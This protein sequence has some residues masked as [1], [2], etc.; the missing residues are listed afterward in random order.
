[1]KGELPMAKK[2]SRLTLFSILAGAAAGTCYYFY[3]KKSASNNASEDC[4]DFDEDLDEDFDEDFFEDTVN[5]SSGKDR[6]YMSID[7]DNAKEIIGEK[8][9][10]TIDKT[11]EKLEQLNVPEKL[12]K[13]KELINDKISP[14]SVAEPV[15]TEVDISASTASAYSNSEENVPDEDLTE[16]FFDDSDPKGNN[17]KSE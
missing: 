8:V 13:A 14:A 10:E 12:D 4:D 15:Y 3:K 2:F 17:E 1:M 11:K 16:E 6:T 7:L 9:I 5:T